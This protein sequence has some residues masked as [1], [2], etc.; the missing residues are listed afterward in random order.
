MSRCAGGD[1]FK[2][3]MLHGGR[4]PE[5]WVAAEVIAPLL[6]VLH[7]MHALRIMHRDISEYRMTVWAHATPLGFPSLIPA[8]PLSQCTHL[9]ASRARTTPLTARVHRATTCTPTSEPENI[10][11]TAE[12]DVKLGDFGLAIDW[13]HELAFSRSGTLDYMAPEVLINPATHLQESAAV[14]APQ[15]AAKNIRPYT[16]AV[17]FPA[18]WLPDD[19]VGC[20]GE[21][22]RK[23]GSRGMAAATPVRVYSEP[24]HA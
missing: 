5:G 23:K 24:C 20:R 11:L 4:L 2:K 1:L 9:P 16:A 10:F 8:C 15:L 18:C 3:L 7:R 17:S 12:G 14:T 19:L 21:K 6:Q 22:H 13:S